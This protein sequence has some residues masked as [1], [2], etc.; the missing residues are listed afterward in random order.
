MIKENNIDR[1]MVSFNSVNSNNNN[2]SV[3][4]SLFMNN[5]DVEQIESV[6]KKMNRYNSPGI[7]GLPPK[8]FWMKLHQY[9]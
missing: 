3:H 4:D 1:N 8:F 5:T 6:V 2:N 9:L 7:N